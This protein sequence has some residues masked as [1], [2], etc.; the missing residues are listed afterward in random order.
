MGG[1]RIL[2][3]DVEQKET[4]FCD[5]DHVLLSAASAPWADIL[6]I[7]HHRLGPGEIS[8]SAPQ[9]FLIVERINSPDEIAYR[10][11]GERWHKRIVSPGDLDLVSAGAEISVRW[12]QPAEVL[13]LALNPAFVS[14]TIAK[15]A[16]KEHL[17]FRN[18]QGLKD[19]QIQ[20]IVSALCTELAQGYPSGRLFGESLATALVIRIA[21]QYA[22][23]GVEGLECRGGLPAARLHRVIDYIHQHLLEDTSLS[24]LARVADL[25]PHHFA[26]LFKESVGVSPHRYVMLQKIEAAKRLLVGNRHSLAEIAHQAGFPSQAHFSTIFRK[27][28]GISPGAYRIH[29]RV[30]ARD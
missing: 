18:S 24:Q 30:Q 27:L 14:A 28:T 9:D 25:S 5:L 16:G 10:L 22:V 6:K 7:E 3:R 26:T 8:S 19:T 17:E 12:K 11:A 20:H 21:S 2:I 13:V 29:L 4:P 1:P 15:A 23:F